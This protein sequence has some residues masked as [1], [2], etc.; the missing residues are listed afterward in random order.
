MRPIPDSAVD[1]GTS[2]QANSGMGVWPAVS[3]AVVTMSSGVRVA[4]IP[5]ATGWTAAG[6]DPAG[7]S[8]GRA[9]CSPKWR[10]AHGCDHRVAAVGRYCEQASTL[11][12]AAWTRATVQGC[13]AALAS[14]TG[15]PGCWMQ[16]RRQRADCLSARCEVPVGFRLLRGAASVT[17]RERASVSLR[18]RH[19]WRALF[20]RCPSRLDDPEVRM[21]RSG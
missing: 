18:I 12:D 10:V 5:L 8:R 17:A 20:A 11:R 19:S 16:G 9:T 14:R 15:V 21:L 13:L 7:S 6:A 3:S 4:T 1:P 2:G